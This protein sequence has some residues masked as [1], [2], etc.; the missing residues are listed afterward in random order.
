MAKITKDDRIRIIS[1]LVSQTAS[2]IAFEEMKK[3]E[4]ENPNELIDTEVKDLVKQ[5]AVSELMFRTCYFRCPDEEIEELDFRDQFTAWFVSD[6]EAKLR[7]MCH[8]N[9]A[10]ELQKRRKPGEE[11]LT[12][13]E[14]YLK[15]VREEGKKRSTTAILSDL[16]K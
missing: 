10:S 9:T 1:E 4:K 14:R 12:F 2:Q 15:K 11:N 6:E 8:S 13:T 7:N 5:R 16:Y 3:F